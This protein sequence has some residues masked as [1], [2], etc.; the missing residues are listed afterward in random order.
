MS[1]G[2]FSKFIQCSISSFYFL[3]SLH[4]ALRVAGSTG[5]Y[6][7]CHSAKAGWL[8][9][10]I[11]SSSHTRTSRQQNFYKI[12]W[13]NCLTKT[14]LIGYHSLLCKTLYPRTLLQCTVGER[15]KTLLRNLKSWEPFFFLCVS[16]QSP[17]VSDSVVNLSALKTKCY[18]TRLLLVL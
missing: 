8:T 12:W 14:H 11:A 16:V 17:L 10:Q 3:H 5:A 15:V 13:I 6:L 7:C 2:V 4:S 9:D 1:D 18:L